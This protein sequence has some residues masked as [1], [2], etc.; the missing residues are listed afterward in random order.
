MEL[1]D[2]DISSAQ[3]Q[4]MT[5]LELCQR[6]RENQARYSVQQQQQ[7]PL[8]YQHYLERD[9]IAYFICGCAT[10]LLTQNFNLYQHIIFRDKLC[11]DNCNMIYFKLNIPVAG[12][13][14]SIIKSKIR[15]E[16]IKFYLN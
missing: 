15:K 4:C 8:R 12:Q 7:Q 2:S 1:I 13:N 11:H 6:S 5:E 3:T 10:E 16:T 14:H 9:T